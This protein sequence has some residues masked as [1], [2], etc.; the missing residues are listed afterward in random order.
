MAQSFIQCDQKK[1]AKCLKKLPKNYFTKKWM[2]STPLQ[3]LYKNVG[4]FGKLI[5]AKGFKK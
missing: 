5:A 1:I 2:I 3:K 4:Y